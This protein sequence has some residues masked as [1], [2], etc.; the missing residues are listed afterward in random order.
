MSGRDGGIH[1]R[2]RDGLHAEV[3]D[4]L[5]RAG[6]RYSAGRRRLIEVLA[7]A[8]RP[9]TG[10]EIVAAEPGLALSS[11]Y[12]NLGVLEGAQI[13]RRLVTHEDTAKYELAESLTEHHHHLVCDECGAVFDFA[14]PAGL[15]RS[16]TRG[17]ETVARATGFQPRSHALEIL[18]RCANCAAAG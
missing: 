9:L 3:A 1:A 15:E 4:A 2:D 6:Q 8:P 14:A 10:P 13:V 17:L 18:G 7:R 5:A 12:R 16:L 11:V